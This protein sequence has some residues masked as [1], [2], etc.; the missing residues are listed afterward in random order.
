VAAG[1]ADR[2][3]PSVPRIMGLGM[4]DAVWNHAVLSKNRDRLLTSDVAQQYFAEV[5]P[6]AKKLMLDEP[7]TV[8]GTLIQAW[9]H[10][11]VFARK[12][13]PTKAIMRHA[14]GYAERDAALLMIKQKQD[15]RS[16]RL[17]VGAD[18]LT[19]PRISLAWC[20]S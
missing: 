13:A 15:S 3:Q 12:T 10:R 17:T 5:N 14:D 8:D 6:R 20:G 7:F 2:L 9:P 16:R 19:T 1:R 4:D 11:R 18:R